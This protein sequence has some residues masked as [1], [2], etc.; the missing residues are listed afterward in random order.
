MRGQTGYF[1]W[2]FSWDGWLGMWRYLRFTGL[3]PM[4]RVFYGQ[5]NLDGKG[6][7]AIF[8]WVTMIHSVKQLANKKFIISLS[9][10]FS[11]WIF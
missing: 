10:H 6:K 9:Q 3:V 4:L 8:L 11:S 2:I 7:I 1:F 5:K